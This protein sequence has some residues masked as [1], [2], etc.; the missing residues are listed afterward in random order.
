MIKRIFLVGIII[1]T[2]FGVYTF[3]HKPIIHFIRV[4]QIEGDILNFLNKKEDKHISEEG[5]IIYNYIT[6]V[7]NTECNVSAIVEYY[8]N[9][10]DEIIQAK[11]YKRDIQ[12]VKFPQ[13][14][15]NDFYVNRV[16]T[17]WA[18]SV[19]K[20]ED[21]EEIQ[22]T[23]NDKEIK[24][25]NQNTFKVELSKELEKLMIHKSKNVAEGWYVDSS[26]IINKNGI[27]ELPYNCYLEYHS[28]RQ[29][30]YAKN[31]EIYLKSKF[32]KCE[33]EKSD[34]SFDFN[35]QGL[36]AKIIYKSNDRSIDNI[37]A[38]IGFKNMGTYIELTPNLRAIW[39]EQ[40]ESSGNS[41]I[42]LKSHDVDR[43]KEKKRWYGQ[44][45]TDVGRMLDEGISMEIVERTE[46]I[47][48]NNTGTDKAHRIIYAIECDFFDYVE[49]G[50]SKEDANIK[51]IDNWYYDNER[52]VNATIDIKD[53]LYWKGVKNKEIIEKVK[54]YY[55]SDLPLEEIRERI[56]SIVQQYREYI[57]KHGLDK[58]SAC[59]YILNNWIYD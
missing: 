8:F 15:K 37:W 16:E 59:Q 51:I 18:G 39:V 10:I 35:N 46:K 57:D 12:N 43:E 5:K 34:I 22:N 49:E 31:E 7:R 20:I 2:L 55:D 33:L 14:Y 4:K 56:E 44:Q 53:M 50:F 9:I 1:A 27:I 13:N 11:V 3:A 24:N 40:S 29:I 32:I 54:I 45:V 26:K 28:G 21:F 17:G 52:K 38:V 19:H 25:Y 42:M 47:Y 6:D 30:N 41:Y 58:E 48:N 36:T 23:I